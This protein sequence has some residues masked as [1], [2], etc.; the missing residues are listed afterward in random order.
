MDISSI[1]IG[2][3]GLKHKDLEE[4]IRKEP[5]V[6]KVYHRARLFFGE[7]PLISAG[8]S[9]GF[10]AFIN[11]YIQPMH[12]SPH[13][14]NP[15]IT[16]AAMGAMGYI[17]S[18]L[19]VKKLYSELVRKD[20]DLVQK[21]HNHAV[22]P[23]SILAI[24][25]TFEPIR[26][27]LLELQYK[28]A[29]TLGAGEILASF[30]YAWMAMYFCWNIATFALSPNM[31]KSYQLLFIEGPR[32]DRKYKKTGDKQ[33][34]ER[35]A[36]KV[37]D[38][39]RA[40]P[41]NHSAYI[42][43]VG[44]YMRMGQYDE[45]FKVYTGMFNSGKEFATG[46]QPFDF[47]PTSAFK[48]ERYLI[49]RPLHKF[50][51]KKIESALSIV[52][53]ALF[54]ES[55]AR[56]AVKEFRRF[57]QQTKPTTELSTVY[58]LLLKAVNHPEAWEQ[59]VK[60]VGQIVSDKNLLR[61]TIGETVN[62]V[63]TI[64]PS[65]FLRNTFIFKESEKLSTLEG[66]FR[67]RN[68]LEEVIHE[69]GFLLPEVFAEPQQFLIDGNPVNLYVMQR[70]PGRT[71][72]E[73]MIET[74]PTQEMEN[75]KSIAGLN[76]AIHAEIPLEASK[77]GRTTLL[78]RLRGKLLAPYLKDQLKGVVGDYRKLVRQIISNY[79]PVYEAHRDSIFGLNLDSHLEQFTRDSEGPITRLDTEDKGIAPLQFDLVNLLEYGRF[80]SDQQKREVIQEYISHYN[81]R[82][83]P[84]SQK[85][86]L[87][88]MMPQYYNAVVERAISLCSAWSS[89]GRK[90][91]WPKRQEIIGAAVDSIDKLGAE[92]GY[93]PYAQQYAS[94][95]QALVELKSAFNSAGT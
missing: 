9:A 14:F 5:I 11:Y 60:L 12:P 94:L 30:G 79:R 91:L 68:T 20:K 65:S 17:S 29:P 45:A 13:L 18:R 10:A 42:K 76:A 77:K 83:K 51:K 73:H 33:A 31:R 6:P 49:L 71:L 86:D 21:L 84:D 19:S 28:L 81:S 25:R 57:L 47:L 72:L 66:E 88:T 8:L 24:Y 53:H 82:L 85:I 23:S 54:F 15:G 46:L 67:M 3:G 74:G 55:D 37:K 48:L 1:A 58:S 61:E 27:H 64:G 78:H 35:Y 32:E 50:R 41:S 39:I 40:D 56:A 38:M 22:L 16:V 34:Y 26:M 4:I 7:H 70:A 59:W 87:E 44:I 92:Y 36:S 43:L 75:I 63:Y 69:E 93:G 89:P 80:F 95:R 62:R 2:V 52:M 90:S